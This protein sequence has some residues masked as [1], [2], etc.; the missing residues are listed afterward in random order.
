MPVR[1]LDIQVIIIQR[2]CEKF[3]S[4][5]FLPVLGEIMIVRFC[6]VI[7]VSSSKDLY[8]KNFLCLSASKSFLLITA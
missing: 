6:D 3:K 7:N 1:L 8:C 5:S 2:I 4:L